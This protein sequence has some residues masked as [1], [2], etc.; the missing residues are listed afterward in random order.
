M[1]S[2]QT[3]GTKLTPAAR[4]PMGFIVEAVAS[5]VLYDVLTLRKHRCVKDHDLREIIDTK[6]HLPELPP[7]AYFDATLSPPP[8]ESLDM[9]LRLPGG[10][11]LYH[12]ELPAYEHTTKAQADIANDLMNQVAKDDNGKPALDALPDTV[13][14][15]TDTA[16][17]ETQ[18]ND[19]EDYGRAELTKADKHH[20]FHVNDGVAQAMRKVRGAQ[21]DSRV[22]QEYHEWSYC[23]LYS[24]NYGLVETF[25]TF[26]MM[27]A[28]ADGMPGRN[29]KGYKAQNA[30]PWHIWIKYDEL[31]E[32]SKIIRRH[33]RR[34]RS[35][36]GKAL[37]EERG[38][39][40]F[41][42]A[43]ANDVEQD[44][45]YQAAW[46]V[47]TATDDFIDTF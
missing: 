45:D 26:K 12:F 15:L 24:T 6:Q 35:C 2:E 41:D 28:N 37:W 3:S 18:Y 30:P 34:L 8:K 16:Q 27:Y 46:S 23:C 11:P 44:V 13:K 21:D 38:F 39:D 7:G 25:Q 36:G 19:A 40:N 29:K 20:R 42:Q 31:R 47:L 5:K 22:S 33:R 1:A 14:N 4:A 32:V 10:D 9:T 17:G 43:I